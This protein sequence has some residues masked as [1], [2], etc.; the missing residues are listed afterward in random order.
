M[1]PYT[2]YQEP[3]PR[4]CNQLRTKNHK[5]MIEFIHLLEAYNEHNKNS[6]HFVTPISILFSLEKTNSNFDGV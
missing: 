1:P 4:V 2:M 5:E 3:F 6:H